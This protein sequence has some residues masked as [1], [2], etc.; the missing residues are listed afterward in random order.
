MS[1]RKL[2]IREV[3]ERIKKKS[4][5]DTKSGWADDLSDDL[6]KKIKFTISSK[7]LSRYYDSFV[8]EIKEETGIE[9]FIL[10]KLS[11]YLDYKDFEDFSNTFIKKNEEAKS[12]IVKVSVDDGEET[13]SKKISDIFI[14]ITNTLE[15]NQTF[16]LSEFVKQNGMGILGIILIISIFIGN[17]HSSKDTL[18]KIITNPLNIFSDAKLETDRKYMYWSG[19]RYIATDSNYISPLVKPIAMD[20]NRFI[21]FKKITKPD[22][23]TVENAYGKVWCSK[24]NNEVD[25]FTMDGINPDNDKELKE[26]SEHMILTYGKGE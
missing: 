8:A 9:A 10:N 23:L 6:E 18:N 17:H 1:K 3:F 19:E 21:H 4:S 25:F 26:A 20:K 22:T 16:N 7:T 5:R 12:T 15:N 2:L 11:E 14:T 24:S 13:L